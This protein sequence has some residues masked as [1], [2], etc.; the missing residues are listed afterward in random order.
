MRGVCLLPWYVSECISVQE[1]KWWWWYEYIYVCLCIV[2][3]EETEIVSVSHWVMYWWDKMYWHM[4]ILW[5][6]S[7]RFVELK[8]E[9][10]IWRCGILFGRQRRRKKHIV[11]GCIWNHW[12]IFHLWSHFK[13]S[14]RRARKLSNLICIDFCGLCFRW[15]LPQSIS[16]R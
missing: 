16:V 14:Q 6:T 4:C 8:K 3:P 12:D 15:A 13:N 11:L 1:W 5:S 9:P 7:E 10:V 2:F